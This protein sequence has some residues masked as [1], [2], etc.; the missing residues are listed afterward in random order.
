MLSS[1][2]VLLWLKSDCV[3]FL[4]SL[5]VF[6]FIFK[7]HCLFQNDHSSVNIYWIDRRWQTLHKFCWYLKK[8]IIMIK[9]SC[10]HAYHSL[11]LKKKHRFTD[12]LDCWQ[13]SNYL[14]RLMIVD[15]K[16]MFAGYSKHEPNNFD[17]H[18]LLYNNCKIIECIDNFL[19]KQFNW[20]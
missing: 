18:G 19:P 1:G 8:K 17:M 10:L 20:F 7:I 11:Y 5:H 14:M 12:I 6:D 13:C 3:A 4:F 15:I 9:S 16:Q 2:M